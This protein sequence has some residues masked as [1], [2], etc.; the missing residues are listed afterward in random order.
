[1]GVF[2]F[3]PP[4]AAP[5]R[6]PIARPAEHRLHP[7]LATCLL[8]AVA[9]VLSLCSSLR[10]G[11]PAIV[12]TA[13]LP[14]NPLPDAW[15]DPEVRAAVPHLKAATPLQGRARRNRGRPRAAAGRG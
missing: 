13:Q 15:A 12:G 2:V 6:W 7:R 3:L 14:G 4:R 11:L 10:L 5:D 9:A 1:M 8:S